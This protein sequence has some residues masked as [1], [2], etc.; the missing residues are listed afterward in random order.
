M[1]KLEYIAWLDK[2]IEIFS[3]EQRKAFAECSP[4]GDK[5]GYTYHAKHVAF[6][7]AKM[8]AERLV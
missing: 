3:E 5:R 6:Y 2:Q 8:M 1:S 4:D 7:E